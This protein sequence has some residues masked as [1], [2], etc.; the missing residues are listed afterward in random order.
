MRLAFHFTLLIL[1]VT[2]SPLAPLP[3]QL[4]RNH[5]DGH[6]ECHDALDNNPAFITF[7]VN[8]E[9]AFQLAI[10]TAHHTY[11][12]KLLRN[13]LR[14]NDFHMTH[15]PRD[16]KCGWQKARSVRARQFIEIGR[17]RGD[18]FWRYSDLRWI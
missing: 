11:Y 2:S 9:P 14:A 16:Q 12:P 4:D 7:H 8:T 18:I 15:V 5:T 10:D 3:H 17:H 1:E 13:A 6:T